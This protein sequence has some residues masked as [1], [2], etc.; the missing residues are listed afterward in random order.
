MCISERN[1]SRQ[2]IQES[3]L[4]RRFIST[5]RIKSTFSHDSRREG[6]GGGVPPSNRLMGCAAG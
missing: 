5:I 4:Y 1:C 2:V 3:I 6:G